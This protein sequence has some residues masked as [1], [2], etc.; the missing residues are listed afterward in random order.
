MSE[1]TNLKHL[2]VIQ[3]WASRSWGRQVI[4]TADQSVHWHPLAKASWQHIPDVSRK[5]FHSQCL[6]P[7]SLLAK[8]PGRCIPRMFR[9]RILLRIS[10]LRSAGQEF[11]SMGATRD[12]WWCFHFASQKKIGLVMEGSNWTVIID[13]TFKGYLMSSFGQKMADEVSPTHHQLTCLFYTHMPK[14]FQTG[15]GL[16][17]VEMWY[18]VGI[19]SIK[20]SQSALKKFRKRG[21]RRGR[22]WAKITQPAFM[23]KTRLAFSLQVSCLAS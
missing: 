4:L 16:V 20:T 17:D 2:P 13:S 23:S 15:L 18:T 6:M 5:H 8:S 12:A 21:R 22:D 10:Q 11:W 7:L 9:P 1:V 19:Y 3:S 14:F